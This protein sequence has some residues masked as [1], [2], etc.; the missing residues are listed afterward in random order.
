V[1]IPGGL[2]FWRERQFAALAARSEACPFPLDQL[3]RTMG[4]W[5]IVEG[6]DIRLDPEVAL[7]AGA[8]DHIVRDYIDEKSGERASVLILYGL[9]NLVSPHTPGLCYTAA[10]YQTVKG[11]TDHSITVPGVNG[12][13]H[14]RWAIYTKRVGRIGR[15]EESY[16][17]F[18]HRRDW[19]PDAA[20]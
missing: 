1:G 15:Y 11:P 14:Y 9:G 6:S 16:V 4:T 20:A 12:P 10:G 2:R 7:F 18:L 17:T 13:V 8:S 19:V 3:P 5:R